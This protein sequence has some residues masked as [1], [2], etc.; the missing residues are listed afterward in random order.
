MI[1][2]LWSRRRVKPAAYTAYALVYQI[3]MNLD[4]A[5]GEICRVCGGE[6][7]KRGPPIPVYDFDLDEL[8]RHRPDALKYIEDLGPQR[9]IRRPCPFQQGWRCSIHEFKPYACLCYP[10]MT[11]E[12][13]IRGIEKYSGMGVPDVETDPEC[14]AGLAIK[15]TVDSIVDQLR[16]ELKRDPSPTELLERVVQ[17]YRAK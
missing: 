7:C 10:F 4:P 11:E 9:V 13:A 8:A 3:A 6:C 16:A 14:R 2:F 1:E 17:R 5:L 15:E 12:V